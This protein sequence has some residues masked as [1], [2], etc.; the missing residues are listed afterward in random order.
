MDKNE[1]PQNGYI[2]FVE[3]VRHEVYA[4]NSF[5]AQEAAKALYKGRK[6]YPSIS[7]NLCELAGQQVTGIIVN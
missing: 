5:A 2:A 3:G 4:A 6:K 1:A 7:V